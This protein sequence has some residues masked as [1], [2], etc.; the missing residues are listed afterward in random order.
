VHD[1]DRG[2]RELVS[3]LLCCFSERGELSIE[4]GRRKLTTDGAMY[5]GRH[6]LAIRMIREFC[7]AHLSDP[8]HDWL[9][10]MRSAT[11]NPVAGF[12]FDDLKNFEEPNA[13]ARR[14]VIENV[15]EVLFPEKR[16]TF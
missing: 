8:N 11:D 2:A 6:A 3:A 16:G 9:Q 13:A 7:E 14:F 4:D 12:D 10:Y 1:E 15:Y 5:V